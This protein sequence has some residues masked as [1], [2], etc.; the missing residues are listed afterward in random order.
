MKL[1]FERDDCGLGLASLRHLGNDNAASDGCGAMLGAMACSPWSGLPG[2]TT[3]T[4]RIWGTDAAAVRPR[5]AESGFEWPAGQ[6][7]DGSGGP[8]GGGRGS[9]RGGP[10][11]G[12]HDGTV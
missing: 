5:E 11:G 3:S 4:R 2:K 9:G 12:Q 6:S 10:N 8:G 1:N 7:E